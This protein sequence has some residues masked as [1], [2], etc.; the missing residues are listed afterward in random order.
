[1]QKRLSYGAMTAIIL[2]TLLLDQ[3]SK[4]IIKTNMHLGQSIPVLGNFF[5]I[6]YVENPGMAFGVRI[7]NGTLFSTLSIIAALLVFYYL[8]RLRKGGWVLQSALSLIAAGA[9]GNLLD[10]FLYGKVVDFLDFEFF[11]I[12]IPAFRIF[13]F[14][15]SGYNMTR[16]PV[17]NVA[18]SAV[19]IGMMLLIA[20]ILFWGD[21]LKNLTYGPSEE[22]VDSSLEKENQGQ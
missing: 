17:F 19:T 10:R 21:P 12:S 14:N 20:Y 9:I 7:Q 1:M 8:F 3:V 22:N 6:T 16:W 18:D 5:R 11:D 15:F 4:Y 2:G 13:G